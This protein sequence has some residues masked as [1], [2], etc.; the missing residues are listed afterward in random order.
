MKKIIVLS[1]LLYCSLYTVPVYAQGVSVNATG[2]KPD[3]SAILDASAIDK[4]F[5]APRVT[6]AQRNAFPKLSQGLIIYNLDENCLN[7]YTGSVWLT[8]C[9]TVSATQVPTIHVYTADTL[10]TKPVGVKY[11]LV[12]LVGGGGGGGGC[13]SYGG[14]AGA[15]AGYSRKIIAASSLSATETVSVGIGGTGG[16]PITAGGDGGTSSF[17]AHCSAT[18]GKGGVG[19][20]A[21]VKNSDGS[22]GGIGVGGDL[23]IS[24]QSSG[25]AVGSAEPTYCGGS[26]FF[27]G[28]APSRSI[29]VAANG[30]PASNFG[31]GG[32]GG[33]CNG[34]IKSGGN[35]SSG[36]VVVTE[37]Y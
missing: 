35:G 33:N 12:E 3:S 2:A 37:F 19:Q 16:A 24:G 14:G 15:G 6:T 27:G 31:S 4:G 34:A 11:I 20:T 21:A 17:G 22:Q 10:W 29:A 18:G 7:Y 25:G 13:Q 30:L 32:S 1:F 9:G 28:G 23:N 8:M 5:L 36:V 26:S